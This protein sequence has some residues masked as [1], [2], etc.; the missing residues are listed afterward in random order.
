MRSDSRIERTIPPC[1]FAP[2]LK[3]KG[4]ERFGAGSVSVGFEPIL[5]QGG[6][7]ANGVRWMSERWHGGPSERERLTQIKNDAKDQR[8]AGTRR[9][10]VFRL[11]DA[12]RLRFAASVAG[13]LFESLRSFGYNEA[14]QARIGRSSA[15]DISLEVSDAR[16]SITD[17]RFRGGW[18]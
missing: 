8:S 3:G 15:G 10:L 5:P 2:R 12:C 16:H 1:A 13:N 14:A 7:W 11:L 17:I 18:R 9:E 6:T 4:V